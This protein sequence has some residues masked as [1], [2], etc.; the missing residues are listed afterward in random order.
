MKRNQSTEAQKAASLLGRRSAKAR[1]RKW[2]KAQFLRKMRAW[3]KTGGR[4]KGKKRG[5]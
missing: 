1:I 3:G 4:P 5:K 2:G